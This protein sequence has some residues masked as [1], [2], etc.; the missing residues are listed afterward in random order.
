MY[1]L[2]ADL[3]YLTIQYVF[4]LVRMLSTNIYADPLVQLQA[5]PEH[6]ATR[7]SPLD[8]PQKQSD[9]LDKVDAKAS[10]K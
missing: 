8:K 5:P 9:L 4:L 2:Y 6:N 1:L 7:L 10:D 3:S